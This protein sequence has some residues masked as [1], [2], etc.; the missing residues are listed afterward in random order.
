MKRLLIWVII[1]FFGTLAAQTT[2]TFTGKDNLGNY[3]QLHSIIVENL[4]KN[5]TDT[6]Y[7]PDTILIM[8]GVGLPDYESASE[9]SV[10]QNVPNPFEGVTDF[11]MTLPYE[12][13]ICIEVFDMS[14]RKVTGKEHRL[15]AGTHTFRV[16]LSVPQTYL[17]TVKTSHDAATI[18][19]VNNG[20]AGRNHIEYRNAGPLTY[21]LRAM[22][23]G[24]HPFE[25][26][27]MMRYTG[28]LLYNNVTLFSDTIEQPQYGDETF[29]LVFHLWG[30]IQDGGHFYSDQALFIPDGTPCNGSCIGVI[31][32]DV[33]GYP[34]GSVIESAEDIHY[35][36]LKMEHS[37]IGDLWISLVCPNGQ[38]AAILKK[39]NTYSNDCTSSIPQ[40]DFGWQTSDNGN[41]YFGQYYKPDSPGCNPAQNPMGIC[42]NYCWSNNVS[43][44]YQYSCSNALVYESCNHIYATNPSPNGQ[45]NSSYV[46]STNVANMTNV[47]HP[48]ISFAALTGCP[49]NGHWEI[50]VIDG[51]VSDNGY[52]EEA[53]IAL[54]PDSSWHPLSLPSVVTGPST[55]IGYT[56]AVCSGTVTSSGLTDVT[57]RGFCWDTVPNPTVSG[58]HNVE[59][60]GVGTFS[61]T[62]NNL[63]DGTTYYYRAYATNA[64]GT[65]YGSQL[66][67][68]T[69]AYNIPEVT[70]STVTGITDVSAVSGGTVSDNGGLPIIEQGICW[71]TEQNPTTADDHIAASSPTMEN[72]TCDITSLTPNTTYYVRAYAINAVG[73]GYGNILSFTTFNTPLGITANCTYVSNTNADVNGNI[74]ADGGSSLTARGFCWSVSPS[75]TL[76]DDYVTVSGTS[77]GAFTGHV[78][79][80]MPGTTYYLNAFAT[81]SVGTAYSADVTFT[82]PATPVVTTTAVHSVTP[83][84]A[85][86]GGT[87]VYDGGL[88][89]SDCG[90]CWSTEPSPS[91]DDQFISGGAGTGD[92]VCNLTDLEANTQYYVR[93]YATN[94]TVTTYGETVSFITNDSAFICGVSTIR[95]YDDNIYHTVA[96]GTQCWMKENMRCTRF[97]DGT[98]IP[99]SST[100]SATEAAR[101]YPNGNAANLAEYGYL[102]SWSAAMHGNP[103][104]DGQGICPDGWH[105]PSKEEWQSLFSYVGSRPPYACGGFSGNY[106]KALAADHT[107][108]GASG[109]C[110]IGNGIA[111][112]NAT[113]FS[114]IPAGEHNGSYGY[115]NSLAAFHSSYQEGSYSMVFAFYRDERYVFNYVGTMVNRLLSVRC[116]RDMAMNM[117]SLVVITNAADSI[118]TSSALISYSVSVYNTDTMITSGV[119]WST[120]PSPSI[121]DNIISATSSEAGNHSILLTDLESNTVYY[122]RAFATNTSGTVY[123]QQRMFRTLDTTNASST[124][125]ILPIV[126]TTNISNA[127]NGSSAYCD[128]NV[129]FD[130]YSTVTERGICWSTSFEPTV[131]GQHLAS[132]SGTGAFTAKA[133]G[134]TPGVTY[135]LRAYATTRAGT[136]YGEELTLTV[137]VMPSVTTLGASN[138][139]G[140]SATCSG[141]VNSDG[142]GEILA[143]G[144]CWDTLPNPTHSSNFTTEGIT[145]GTFSSTLTGLTPNT[146][147]HARAYITNKVG[148]AYGN[149]VT[150]TTTAIPVITTAP[151]SSISY[152]SAVSGGLDIQD[153]GDSVTETGICW[154]TQPQPGLDGQHL[155][156]SN[157]TSAFSATLTGLTPG[158]RYYVRAYATNSHGTAYGQEVSFMARNDA[159]PCPGDTTVTDFEGNIYHTVQLGEQCWLKENLRSTHYADGSYFTEY[160][161]PNNDIANVPTYGLMYKWATVMHGA[162]SSEIP[163]AVQGIC[164]N[165]WHLPSYSEFQ[166]L[167]NY[168]EATYSCASK[169]LASTTGWHSFNLSGCYA[170]Y[171][172]QL[173]NESGFTV[174]PT[175]SPDSH[176]VLCLFSYSTSFWSATMHHSNNYNTCSYVLYL[177]YDSY[178]A[179]I[180]WY[181][182]NDKMPVRCIRNE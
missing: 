82:T 54:P 16:W 155:A 146:T 6:L 47:Y 104:V 92:F 140:I 148:T 66:T 100:A 63:A 59:G 52:V 32:I 57:E 49:I 60:A 46:D 78:T 35:L 62:L 80:L 86:S 77:T 131:A 58:S 160:Y 70:T 29:D 94:S 25:P 157:G 34:D 152:T 20:N 167:E 53:E 14:G 17:L 123:G 68:T 112:N 96:I 102:Y 83:S 144:I 151:I 126:R 106:A 108:L 153:N 12:S 120:E 87:V 93:A 119:C 139:E 107:W 71:S 109:T 179:D 128:G 141:S 69:M 15:Y 143:L 130:G 176:P 4:T 64:I 84:S 159:N 1:C 65:A 72:F 166:I 31:G 135:Y 182:V 36:R 103:P 3:V 95:D 9:F 7:Y 110:E 138:I 91:L 161:Y 38:A 114:M 45:S 99:L 118:T 164:P 76:Q 43:E 150:F 113:D 30:Q 2:L 98:L 18:K 26:G 81:N 101:C 39:R 10:S 149:D 88:L 79:G 162:A 75:P 158:Y 145:L 89:V 28:V 116:L 169:A 174:Y 42:W 165:G 163:G 172:P 124:N 111:N 129:L 21:E 168:S 142:Y 178:D 8:S 44:G 5:W 136:A 154:S 56:S 121:A 37:F 133:N 19:M 90:I 173:N 170:G 24:E 55:A 11:T 13:D 41:V 127:F 27:D 132:G 175:G 61:S 33:S 180:T 147:Y 156:I 73:I 115:F 105:I 40:S 137:P 122:V 23:G 181:S 97:P 74:S 171:N 22:M 51:Y 67:F 48:D 134:L 117:P 125:P 85:I 177:L 50:R